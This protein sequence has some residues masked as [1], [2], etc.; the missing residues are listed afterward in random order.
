VLCVPVKYT[1]VSVC[2]SLALLMATAAPFLPL[3]FLSSLGL[4]FG[5]WASLPLLSTLPYI[6]HVWHGSNPYIWPCDA[7]G[8]GP[9]LIYAPMWGWMG[10]G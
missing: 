10:M 9:V 5:L 3:P 4:G 2:V 7:D 6:R 1:Y 8:H